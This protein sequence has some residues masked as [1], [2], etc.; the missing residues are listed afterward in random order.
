MADSSISP[1][2]SNN[3]NFDPLTAV[4]S[5]NN[6]QIAASLTSGNIDPKFAVMLLN[7]MTSNNVNSILFGNDQQAA[8]SD[9]LG[10]DMFNTTS[11]LSPNFIGGGTQDIFGQTSLVSPQYEMSVYSSLIGKTITALNPE[12]G[13]QITDKVTGVL[14]QN[15]KV[16]L[17]VN[18]VI[19]PTENLLKIK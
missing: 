15:G 14:L 5:L 19:I 6:T 16:V 1:V 8:S 3:T 17:D 9:Y 7:Q 13:Q 18:G 12:T 4:S 10:T 11:A 2:T